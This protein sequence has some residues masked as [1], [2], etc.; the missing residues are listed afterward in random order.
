MLDDIANDGRNKGTI[1]L[2]R[3]SKEFGCILDQNIH[4]WI[5]VWSCVPEP[6]ARCRDDVQNGLLVQ[7]AGHGHQQGRILARGRLSVRVAPAKSIVQISFSP[8]E[9]FRGSKYTKLLNWKRYAQNTPYFTNSSM[10]LQKKFYVLYEFP[11]CSA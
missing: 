7:G 11:G 1:G 5:A 4:P 6:G 10:I 9:F 8:Q 3:E 2:N